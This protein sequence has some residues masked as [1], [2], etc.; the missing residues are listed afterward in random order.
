MADGYLNTCL[1]CRRKYQ[2]DYHR[3]DPLHKMWSGLMGRCYSDTHHL[4][5]WYGG[6][7]VGICPRW[8]VYK[9]FKE[10]VGNGYKAGMTLARRDEDGDFCAENCVW[11]PAWNSTRKH[12]F[13]KANGIVK[14]YEEWEECSGIPHRYIRE[15]V[16]RFGWSPEEA[17]GLKA[18]V[19]KRGRQ[20]REAYVPDTR[21]QRWAASGR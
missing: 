11:A 7:G 10:D 20:R 16:L 2:K 12:E 21:Q 15:R 5:P 19:V 13:L 18:R 3:K 17:V 8:R 6:R 4:Y 9:N 14:T 1:E